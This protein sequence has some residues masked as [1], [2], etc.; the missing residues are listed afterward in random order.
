MES[1]ELLQEIL[2]SPGNAAFSRIRYVR[3]LMAE[4]EQTEFL[5]GLYQRAVEA[6]ESGTLDLLADFLEEWED[7][8]QALA[9]ARARTPE[10]GATTWIPLRLPINRAKVALLTT[11][12]FY[13][14][15]QEPF[16]TDG[17]EGLGDWSYR[18]IPKDVPRDQIRVAHAHYDLSGPQEDI[19]CVFPL[20][21]FAELEKDGTIGSL[22][23]TAYSFM[24]FI[25]RPDLL[26][27]ETAPEVAQ[28]LKEDGVEAVV[29]TST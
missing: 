12:G 15:G 19:N 6:R 16:E 9:G 27:S 3:T 14:E 8:G 23:D 20:D 2:R 17:P 18:A 10:V 22:A 4:E 29:L 28:R 13:I 11:G 24:G 7:K 5:S 25:Q 26:M 1:K 21:V